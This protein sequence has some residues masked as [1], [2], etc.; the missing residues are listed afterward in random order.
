MR[1]ASTIIMVAGLAACATSEPDLPD[2]SAGQVSTPAA[3]AALLNTSGAEIGTMELTAS[4]HG[5]LVR[6]LVTPGGLSA[7]WHGAHFHGV[8]DCSDTAAFQKSGAHVHKSENGHGL[9]YPYGPE[10]GDLPNIS[11]A[12]DGSAAVE[13]FST[14]VT[15][16]ELQDDDGSALI[17]HANADDHVTQPIGGAG[18]RVACAVAP[19]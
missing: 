5:V 11:V 16:A 7:G 1:I 14:F 17:I 18:A 15:L 6:L 19:R 8:G 13:L 2:V 4:P 10:D 9:L 3:S 12:G